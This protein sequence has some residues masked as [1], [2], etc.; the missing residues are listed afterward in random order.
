MAIELKAVAE[1]MEVDDKGR[2]VGTKSTKSLVLQPA[3]EG[4]PVEIPL[5]RFAG[6]T[7]VEMLGQTQLPRIGETPYFLTLAPYGF[8]W[9][10]LCEES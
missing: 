6:L 10:Q 5:S 1:I 2:V 7:P 3:V 8:Y 4:Q 9:F